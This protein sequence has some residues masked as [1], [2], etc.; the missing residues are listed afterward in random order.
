MG[1]RPTHK[2][3]LA[4]ERLLDFLDK[5]HLKSI[6]IADEDVDLIPP[7]LERMKKGDDGSDESPD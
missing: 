3:F 7:F 6:W 2:S 1:R 5:F 4:V